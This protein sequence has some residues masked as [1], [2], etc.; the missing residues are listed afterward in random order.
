MPFFFRSKGHIFDIIYSQIDQI[1]YGKTAMRLI[2]PTTTHREI[3]NGKKIRP[4][5]AG[6]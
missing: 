5:P 6:E 3:C 4:A 2:I 1:T